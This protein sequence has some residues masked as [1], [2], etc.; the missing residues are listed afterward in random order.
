MLI[1]L[2]IRKRRLR[3]RIGRKGMVEGPKAGMRVG[4]YYVLYSLN[5]LEIPWY[6][7]QEYEVEVV[8]R[9]CRLFG[10]QFSTYCTVGSNAAA[11]QVSVGEA[12]YPT[13]CNVCG[14]HSVTDAEK[15]KNNEELGRSE[16]TWTCLPRLA[17]QGSHL[18]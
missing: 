11:T 9:V 1:G 4:R 7:E 3:E 5:A 2:S 12:D 18:V 15:G 17:G 14:R 8:V 10:G 16:R 6:E 13:H